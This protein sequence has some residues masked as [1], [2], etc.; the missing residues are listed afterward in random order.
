M[1]G[2]EPTKLRG[3]K[4]GTTATNVGAG[5]VPAQTQTQSHRGIT[6]VALEMCIRDRRRC[7]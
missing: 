4:Q 7:L 1:K 2:K 5:L 6:L 3:K